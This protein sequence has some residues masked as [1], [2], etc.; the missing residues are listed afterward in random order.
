ML[1]E[2]VQAAVNHTHIVALNHVL[3]TE[4]GLVWP[5]PELQHCRLHHINLS[6][7]Q[8]KTQH[9]TRMIRGQQSTKRISLWCVMMNMSAKD[10]SETKAA[11]K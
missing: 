8:T 6:H 3:H 11:A 9:N 5:V 1:R 10:T 2:R 4:Q 7:M